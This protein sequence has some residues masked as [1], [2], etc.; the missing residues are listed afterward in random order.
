[1]IFSIDAEELFDTT[2]MSYKVKHTCTARQQFP[3]L[4]IYQENANMSTQRLVCKYS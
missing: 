1:M 4:S 3:L 2:Q